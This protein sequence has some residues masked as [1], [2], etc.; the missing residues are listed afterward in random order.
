MSETQATEEIG[1]HELKNPV[2]LFSCTINASLSQTMEKIMGNDLFHTIL[3]LVGDKDIVFSEW[4]DIQSYKERKIDYNKVYSVPVIGDY[5]YKASEI[6]RLFKVDNKEILEIISDLGK[7]PY[8]SDFTP[9]VQL[10]FEPK[11]NSTIYSAKFEMVWKNEPFFIKRIITSKTTDAF[12]DFYIK[13]GDQLQKE[14]Q[15]EN[16]VDTAMN[17]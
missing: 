17:D 1:Y 3:S 13:F 8:A 12:K 7:T 4:K 16:C 10:I 14:F 11:D 6:H 5:L 2:D 9:Y 15:P